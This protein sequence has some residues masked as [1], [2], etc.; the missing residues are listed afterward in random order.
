MLLDTLK[1]YI[2]V[3]K[4]QNEFEELFWDIMNDQPLHLLRRLINEKLILRFY[5]D[6]LESKD[7]YNFLIRDC[8]TQG[9]AFVSILHPIF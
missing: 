8:N 2:E 5:C 1:G 3:F 7:D 6:K 4:P 9:D